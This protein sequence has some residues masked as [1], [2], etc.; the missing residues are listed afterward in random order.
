MKFTFTAESASEYTIYTLTV[1][2]A[3]FTV[4]ETAGYPLVRD[5]STTFLD[6]DLD[7]LDAE[8]LTDPDAFD[9]DLADIRAA[10]G[11]TCNTITGDSAAE[12]ASALD[13]VGSIDAKAYLIAFWRVSVPESE[14]PAWDEFDL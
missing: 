5:D 7:R 8:A 9:T 6:A 3:S 4:I 13:R 12:L 14:R 2:G 11:L 10:D 1:N